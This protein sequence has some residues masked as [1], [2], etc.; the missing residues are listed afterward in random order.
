M[1]P[2]LLLISVLSINYVFAQPGTLDTT[3]NY[4][5]YKKLPSVDNVVRFSNIYFD[6]T[7]SKIFVHGFDRNNVYVWRFNAN[8]SPDS[9]W[10]NYGV[11]KVSVT[12]NYIYES[13]GICSNFKVLPNGKVIF[14]FNDGLI[15]VVRLTE[16]GLLDSTFD[17]T[18]WTNYDGSQGLGDKEVNLVDID[19]DGNIFIVGN[20][21]TFSPYNNAENI[22]FITKLDSSGNFVDSF[23][24][25][26][27]IIL[28]FK[29]D[30]TTINPYFYAQKI[31]AGNKI[32]LAGEAYTEQLNENNLRKRFFLLTR[33]NPNGTIDSTF[34][35]NGCVYDTAYF[36][37]DTYPNWHS[38]EVSSSGD[39]FVGG[40]MDFASKMTFAK[41]SKNGI[42][43]KTF[44]TSGYTTI[45]GDFSVAK[46]KLDK[47][48]GQIYYAAY[49][50]NTASGTTFGTGRLKWDGTIDSTYSIN[51]ISFQN[52]SLGIDDIDILKDSKIIAC[53]NTYDGD[54][55]NENFI[56]RISTSK[57]YKK[58]YKFTGNGNWS[59]AINW[60]GGEIPPNYINNDMEVI[61]SN[62]C[63]LNQQLTITH[64]TKV[65][66][67]KGSKLILNGN[68]TI[69]R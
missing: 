42:L 9:S 33:L 1:R 3:F 43:D 48:N 46:L 44:G 34:G 4:T 27:S 25:E 66:I 49:S 65:T 60:L 29:I 23:S 62:I 67:T 24:N 40:G 32:L 47:E 52:D 28:T 51:G 18:G 36:T 59:D 35:Q 6:T 63:N 17:E 38:I 45:N 69:V 21:Y 14:A 11:A 19:S 30:G 12:E 8:G 7:H 56:A 5:G 64:G 50:N 39:I 58:T 22:T 2:L 10:G 53:G 41:Y 15:Y 68:L 26:S 20:I 13:D 57:V 54:L 31:V 16:N 37:E 61:I 55:V